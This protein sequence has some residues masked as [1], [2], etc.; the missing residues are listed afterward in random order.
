MDLDGTLA[1]SIPF[2][3]AIYRD[4]LMSFAV[5][6]TEEE[7]AKLNGPPLRQVVTLLKQWHGLPGQVDKLLARYEGMIINGYG[8]SVALNRGGR[9]LLEWARRQGIILA[10]I[11]SASS[12]I[13]QDFLKKN[14]LD[15]AFQVLI[16]AGDVSHGK[17]APE[18][19][20]RA[21]QI[22]D[23]NPVEV[24]AVEDSPQGVLSARSAGL[25]VVG[26]KGG[27]PPGALI[28]AGAMAEVEHLG[29][30]GSALQI[31]T[32]LP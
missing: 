2:M 25:R 15:H 17:P 4:F 5:H 12:E 3:K 21:L 24:A 26:K 29:L 32:C 13:A 20:L 28:K 14:G 23:M 16:C 7:F 6:G 30:V 18:P 10:L 22:L 9:D 19:Y 11:T 8:S 31:G 27:W 1:A